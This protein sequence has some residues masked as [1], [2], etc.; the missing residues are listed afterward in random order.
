[1]STTNLK[2]REARRLYSTP[3]SRLPVAVPTKPQPKQTSKMR[4]L[5]RCG[6]GSVLWGLGLL[7]AANVVTAEDQK[8]EEFTCS[9]SSKIDGFSNVEDPYEPF[10]QSC[11]YTSQVSQKANKDY[12][13]RFQGTCIEK[14]KRC[15]DSGRL[16]SD[17][18]M[19]YSPEYIL[20][21]SSRKRVHWAKST[22][23]E[24]KAS[25]SAWKEAGGNH[26]ADVK[27]TVTC[28]NDDPDPTW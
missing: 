20:G 18:K 5:Y 3:H 12:R 10:R 27:L 23:G 19:Q 1:M 21:Y 15:D 13:H 8:F 17:Y 25:T 22:Y 2:I 6:F 4:G 24:L 7:L 26:K 9:L 16:C 28:I 11:V 14:F